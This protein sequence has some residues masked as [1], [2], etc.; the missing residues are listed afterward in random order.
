MTSNLNPLPL[1]TGYTS[2]SDNDT[3]K[4]TQNYDLCYKG[5]FEGCHYASSEDDALQLPTYPYDYGS[6][7][8]VPVYVDSSTDVGRDSIRKRNLRHWNE[9]CHTLN[10]K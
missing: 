10:H 4:C 7:N 2:D 1:F 6:I 8:N 3:T 5:M 9:L